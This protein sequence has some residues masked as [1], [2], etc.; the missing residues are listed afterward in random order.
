[1]IVVDFVVADIHF[2][3]PSKCLG[4]QE[5]AEEPSRLA[6]G[7]RRQR[8]D[9]AGVEEATEV[10]FDFVES[11]CCCYFETEWQIV[12]LVAAVVEVV[13]AVAGKSK[14]Y[15]YFSK[16]QPSNHELCFRVFQFVHFQLQCFDSC[17]CCSL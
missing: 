3:Q 6:V 7:S 12:V 2:C 11:C 14:Y 1:M 13:V 5:L 10:D 8:F 17:C 4:V 15:Y 16:Q 9:L